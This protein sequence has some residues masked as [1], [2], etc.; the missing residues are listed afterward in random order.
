MPDMTSAV[1]GRIGEDGMICDAGGRDKT[2]PLMVG[3]AYL[4]FGR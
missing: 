2:G 3:L 1:M 4:A